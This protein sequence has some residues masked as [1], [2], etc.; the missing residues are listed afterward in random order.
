MSPGKVAGFLAGGCPHRVMVV[1]LSLSLCM[2]VFSPFEAANDK[3]SLHGL[4]EQTPTS[5]CGSSS[6][7]VYAVVVSDHRPVCVCVCVSVC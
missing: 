6:E 3:L 5:S 7:F 1:A 2:C 4:Y